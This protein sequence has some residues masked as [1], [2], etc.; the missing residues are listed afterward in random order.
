M[1]W[2]IQATTKIASA[3]P[4]KAPAE[5][6]FQRQH[7]LIAEHEQ[8]RHAEPQLPRQAERVQQHQ[9]ADQRR[10]VE[11]VLPNVTVVSA[12]AA[13]NTISGTHTRCSC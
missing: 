5:N 6:Q 4:R 9:H 7:R 10:E 3:S 1:S 12:Q 13:E 2:P 11:A 8:Q